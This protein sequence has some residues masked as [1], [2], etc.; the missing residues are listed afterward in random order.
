MADY[1]TQLG[2]FPSKLA[3]SKRILV[4][5]PGDFSVDSLASSLALALALQKVGKNVFVVS[6]GTPLVSHSNLYGIGDIK[7]A[8]PTSGEGN[9]IIKLDGVVDSSGQMNTVPSLEKLDWYPEGSALNLVF[10]VVP[11]QRFEPTKVDYAHETSGF[12]I[13]FVVGAAALDNLGAIYMKNAS[14]FS[15]ATV[16]N[17]DTDSSNS[18][19]GNV[20]VV[21][22]Q[23][24]SIAEMM[25]SLIPNLGLAMDNDIASN[26]VAGLYNATANLTQKVN[27][28]TFA[29]VAAAMQA[30]G[31]L[32][33]GGQSAEVAQEVAEITQSVQEAVNAETVVE[34]EVIQPQ[35]NQIQFNQ[36]SVTSAAPAPQVEPVSQPQLPVVETAQPQPVAQPVSAQPIAPQPEAAPQNDLYSNPFLNPGGQF[37]GGAFSDQSSAVSSQSAASSVAPAPLQDSAFSAPATGPTFNFGPIDQSAADSQQPVAA[38]VADKT[39]EEKAEADA[40]DVS[41]ALSTIMQAKQQDDAYDLKQVF[42]VQQMPET[43]TMANTTVDSAVQRT[44]NIISSQQNQS[45]VVPSTSSGQ[46][47]YQPS[48]VQ[49]QA[50]TQPQ[51]VQDSK[52]Q[53]SPEERPA[54][55]AVTSSNHEAEANPTP[56]WLV[57]KIFKGGSL[58]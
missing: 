56:D 23:S 6:E 7:S 48:E 8:V 38:P 50:T 34:P 41:G 53:S 39:T 42:Q 25:V 12:D 1:L 18:Q 22:S 51:P 19:F 31:K 49:N 28:N 54:G 45:S 30:G 43:P 58:G 29:A 32:P 11:G 21:D 16:V 17:I 9:F 52:P 20:N 2:D 47:S 3:S 26:I 57:P 14:A 40:V 35:T 4:A 5:L 33:E 24:S 36:S 37:S 55:E 27:A 10:H 46:S 44:Q 13:V 15:K